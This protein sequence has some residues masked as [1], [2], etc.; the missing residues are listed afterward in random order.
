MAAM[1]KP[2]LRPCPGGTNEISRHFN[3]GCVR[4]TRLVPKERLKTAASAVPSGLGALWFSTQCLVVE[5]RLQM[6]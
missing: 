6:V 5:P 4:P 3:A 2:R 1:E